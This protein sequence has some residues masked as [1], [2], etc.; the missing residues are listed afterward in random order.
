MDGE[1]NT[2]LG[3]FLRT[4]RAL[5]RPD[6]VGL[7]AR[8][9][10]RVPGLRRDE[11]AHLAGVST[12]Y[13]ARLEQGHQRPTGQTIES[14]ARALRLDHDDATELHR[15]ASSTTARRPRHHGEHVAPHVL[16][17]L[18]DWTAAPAYV[19]GRSNDVLARNA[20]ATALHGHFAHGDNL[21]RMIFLDPAGREFFR[22]RTSTARAAVQDLRRAIGRPADERALRQLIGEL[23]IGSPEFRRS[24]AQPEPRGVITYGSHFVHPDVGELRLSTEVFTVVRAPGQR[25]VAHPADA[26][27]RSAEALVLLGTLTVRQDERDAATS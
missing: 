9:R 12:G 10:R 1:P 26:R 2:A 19:L 22:D 7:N 25:L 23:S 18:H 17:L 27:S 15:L 3:Q 13:Y 8:G 6:Q 24:W 4:R 20:L 11:V 16:S 14:L 5:V 21:L